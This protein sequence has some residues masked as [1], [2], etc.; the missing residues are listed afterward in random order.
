[1]GSQP[2]RYPGRRCAPA[3]I[4]LVLLAHPSSS[5]ADQVGRTPQEEG[6]RSRLVVT[7]SIVG[8]YGRALAES[9]YVGYE[10][11]TGTD[12]D[13]S[14]GASAG[15]AVDLL[16]G[17][18]LGTRALAAGGF[19]RIGAL[20]APNPFTGESDTGLLALAGPRL[21]YSPSALP[22]LYF[23]ASGGVAAYTKSGRA[24]GFGASVGAGHRRAL[25][26]GWLVGV[27]LE[28]A[29]LWT[30]T[31]EDGDHGEYHY[32]D[33]VL[34]VNLVVSIARWHTR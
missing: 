32:R 29:G 26:P 27:G 8:C 7:A 6:Q 1:M 4:A 34:S 24:I 11:E 33:R 13:S 14:K 31:G 18:P 19:L 2:S 23:E 12:E 16:I 3:I 30:Y 20:T 21:V 28:A 22:G 5:H 10:P 15:G 17:V 25:A 9:E